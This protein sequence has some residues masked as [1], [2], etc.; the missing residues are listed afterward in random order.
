MS[1][2]K[3]THEEELAKYNASNPNHIPSE[4]TS[5]RKEVQPAAK[6]EKK[7]AAVSS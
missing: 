3:L 7:V 1:A 6:S 4:G 5:K 2:A